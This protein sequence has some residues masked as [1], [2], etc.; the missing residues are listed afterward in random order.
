M[1]ADRWGLARITTDLYARAGALN[2]ARLAVLGLSRDQAG[3]A[4]PA[5]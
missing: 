5:T 3:W 2:W 4:L 1:V